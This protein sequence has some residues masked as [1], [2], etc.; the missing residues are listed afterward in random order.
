MSNLPAMI[1]S[2]SQ[3]TVQ[4]ILAERVLIS[5]HAETVLTQ[6]ITK[7]LVTRQ[8]SKPSFSP[9]IIG[10]G[11]LN[12][13][14]TKSIYSTPEPSLWVSAPGGDFGVDSSFATGT[15]PRSNGTALQYAPAIMTVDQSACSDGYVRAGVSA[16]NAFQNGD[17]PHSDNLSCNYTSTFN[18]TSSA[19]PNVAGVV[20]LMLEANSD[21][22]HRDVKHILASTARQ[23]DTSFSSDPI[24]TLTYLEWKTNTAGFKF[25]PWYG[26][27][28]VDAASAVSSAQSLLSGSLGSQ[29]TSNWV[30][31]ATLNQALP[32][33]TLYEPTISVA[34]SGTVEWV[35][36]GVKFSHAAPNH[37]GFRLTSPGGTT[38]PLLLP[39][40]K[41]AT[42]PGGVSWIRLPSNAF[43]G[44]SLSGTWTL[45]IVDHFSGTTGTINQWAMWPCIGSSENEVFVYC[46]LVLAL[47]ALAS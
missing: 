34:T 16:T 35:M 18:G 41:S 22:T 31:S 6:V 8:V 12:A 43:Y 17:S 2:K 30:Y 28:A 4:L 33:T 47:Q 7:S 1:T 5:P 25:H 26:F 3:Q 20:A 11:A 42:D 13:N 27:G 14:G 45:S 39:G 37:L 29:S 10:V 38:S 46:S 44:E 36:V 23:V 24:T 15:V 19:A 32:D 40:T 9:F 21:L